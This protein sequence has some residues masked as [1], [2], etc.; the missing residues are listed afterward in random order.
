MGGRA[1][2]LKQADVFGLLVPEGPVITSLD[3]Y[4]VLN[5]SPDQLYRLVKAHQLIPCST[6]GRGPKGKARFA[7]AR[8]IQF[9][10]Q[11]KFA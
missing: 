4:R 7:P 8:V 10:Q 5:I 1:C 3:L 2:S 11:R 9:L 6:W